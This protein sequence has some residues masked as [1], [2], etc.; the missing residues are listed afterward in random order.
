MII[1]QATEMDFANIYDLIKRAFQTAEVS[2]GNEQNFVEELRKRKTY[3]PK[4]EFV[5]EIDDK[6][7]GHVMFSK[8]EVN[9]T[10]GEV[11]ALML[12]P[13]CVDVNYRNK[14]IGTK[15]VHYGLVKAKNLGY[16]AVF[17]LGN[18]EYYKR[19]G[20]KQINNWNLQNG[21]G[22]PDEFVLGKELVANC[23]DTVDGKIDLH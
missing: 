13:L 12:A 16:N 8:Q 6:L 15:L 5:A 17:L 7:I 11:R 18:P 1:R 2:D 4:L 21:S 14:K 20:F 10:K 9:L 3:L 19:F 22:V 23:L